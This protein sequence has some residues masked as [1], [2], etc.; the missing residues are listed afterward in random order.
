[1]IKNNKPSVSLIVSSKS[2][3]PPRL[4]EVKSTEWSFSFKY[5]KQIEN[6]GLQ[7]L[8]P[9]W[10]VS[11][12]DRLKD[13]CNIEVERFKNDSNIKDGFRYHEIDWTAY[14]IPISRADCDWIDQE[15][16]INETDFPFVQFH[17][18]KAFGRIVG[19][20]NENDDMFY[21]V[22]LDP[23]HNIYPS[24]YSEYKIR[25]SHPLNCQYS[26]LLRDIE[27]VR[28]HAIKKCTDCNISIE[29][30]NLPMNLNNT[31]AIIFFLEDVYLDE[32]K[33]RIGNNPISEIIELGLVAY[34]P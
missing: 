2:K 12:I 4:Q 20:W 21:I 28:K 3:T 8:N 1:M 14:N 16:L 13:L 32:F 15:Y 31:N 6:F 23:K 10:F 34:E 22:L 25:D 26:S 24:K 33:K 30:G 18:S 27:V 19:F 9:N 5:F 17:I 29:L 7:S 11:F